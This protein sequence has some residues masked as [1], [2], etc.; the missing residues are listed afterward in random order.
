MM[1][2]TLDDLAVQHRPML[3]CYARALAGG[4]EHR[5]EDIVQ[6]S[7]LVAQRRQEAFREG[8]DYGRW[9]RGIARNKALEASRAAAHRPIPIDSEVIGGID[10][11][12][13]LFDPGAAGE[14]AWRDRLLRWLSECV[15]KLS[16][17]LREAID[18]VYREGLSLRDAARVLSSSSSA[19]AQ[20][21]SRA[22]EMIRAC[23]QAR[24][25]SEF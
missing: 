8:E 6:E 20:R 18:R 1:P 14:E 4:D 15:A 12:F 13:D 24:R 17:H 5:A 3:L 25:E 21:L 7:F 2:T 10:E 9:L 23:V 16:P 11:V 22:R 19:I